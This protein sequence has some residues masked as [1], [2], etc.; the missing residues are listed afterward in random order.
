[1]S[2]NYFWICGTHPVLEVLKKRNAEVK[3]VLLNDE[4]KFN[5]V[6][7]II[8]RKK[9]K[10]LKNS[11]IAKKIQSQI[12]HQG[13]AAKIAPRVNLKKINFNKAAENFL[14]LDGVTDTGNVGSIIR[15]AVAFNFKNIIV[16]EREF[17]S[18]S[19][20][21]HKAAAG[22]L[23]KVNIFEY[24]NIKYAVNELIKNDY[25]I[26]SFDSNSKNF[27]NQSTFKDKNVLIFGSEEKGISKN[28]LKLSH[29]IVKIKTYDVESLN[30]SN[31]ISAVLSIYNYMKS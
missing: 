27:I 23:E 10:I 12:S 29:E 28:I 2:E 15:S 13:F 31:S 7:K 14:I 30:V 6:S 22:N 20:A 8:E 4:E 24:S 16:K 25:Q 3:E 1:M 9:I 18:K 11:D 17:N 5:Q 21:M 19:I 26:I